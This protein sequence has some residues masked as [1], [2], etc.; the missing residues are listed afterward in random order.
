MIISTEII[1]RQ[2]DISDKYIEDLETREQRKNQIEFERETKEIMSYKSVAMQNA[3]ITANIQHK[4]H[5]RK[6]KCLKV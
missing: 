4:I 6:N 2:K 3:F 5:N 1:K